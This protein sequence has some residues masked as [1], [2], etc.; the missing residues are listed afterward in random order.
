[1]RLME[2]HVSSFVYVVLCFV[3]YL[4]SLSMIQ[5]AVCYGGF[6]TQIYFSAR[7]LRFI[8]FIEYKSYFV[9]RIKIQFLSST[10]VGVGCHESTLFFF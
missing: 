2:I 10:N 1:M 4:S 9:V 8:L 3:R 5:V 7:Y 6:M